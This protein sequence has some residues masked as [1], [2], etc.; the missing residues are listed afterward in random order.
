MKPAEKS[1]PAPDKP[2]VSLMF[3]YPVVLAGERR[4]LVEDDEPSLITTS[5]SSGISFPEYKFIDSAGMQYSVRKVTE[6]G[7]KS[8]F[9][10][11]GTSRFQVFL[12]MKPEGKIT[13]QKAKS[14]VLESALKPEGSIGAHGKEIA[15]ERIQ[16]A[17]SVPELIEVWRDP[18]ERK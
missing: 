16:G 17:K 8:A 1:A 10:D 13:L 12:E 9:F 4:L 7:R 2:G 3:S 15:T 14:V 5:V 6:F 11:M 18:Y